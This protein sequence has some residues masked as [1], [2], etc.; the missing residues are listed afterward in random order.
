MSRKKLGFPMAEEN[1]ANEA[2]NEI[3]K[4]ELSE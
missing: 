4:S 2:I 1:Y 3:E